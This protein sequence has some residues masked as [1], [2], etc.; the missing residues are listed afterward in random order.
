MYEWNHTRQLLEIRL[1]EARRE[2]NG[3]SD[4]DLFDPQFLIKRPLLEA[5]DESR[6]RAPG[7]ADRRT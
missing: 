7:P 3:S 4:L 1:M 6:D 2:S 5:I